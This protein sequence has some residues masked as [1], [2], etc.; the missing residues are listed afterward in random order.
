[1]R[2]MVTSRVRK[3]TALISTFK[4]DHDPDPGI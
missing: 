2:V 4:A 1:M 3:G